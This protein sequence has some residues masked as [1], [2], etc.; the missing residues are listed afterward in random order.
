MSNETDFRDWKPVVTQ[1]GLELR[2]SVYANIREFFNSRGVL[3]VDTPILNSF[4]VTDP[5][6]ESLITANQNRNAYLHTSPE[7]AMKRLLAHFNRDIYQICKVFRAEER[8]SLHHPE[9]T[10]L[11]WYR[12]GWSHMELMHEVDELVKNLVRVHLKL[13]ETNYFEYEYLFKEYCNINIKQAVNSD[14]AQACNNAQL[15]LN[16]QLSIKEYQE[17]LMD[18][19]IA[20][21]LPCDCLTF[22]YKFPKEQAALAIINEDDVAERFELYLGKVEL[23][24]GFQEL[25]DCNEQLNRFESDNQIRQ[26]NS[27]TQ[28]EI[29]KNFIAALR[30]GIPESAG[31]AMGIDRLLMLMLGVT[32]IKETLTFPNA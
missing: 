14:Y 10:M 11:E 5:N 1:H 28:I 26:R 21:K 18:Q 8:G 30:A 9:F 24:N 15:S 31:V 13:G 27:K 23:A 20:Y 29:D 7:Y 6:I 22:I 4:A 32:D 19:V 17:L 3:E 2:A 16:I 25:T 12:T